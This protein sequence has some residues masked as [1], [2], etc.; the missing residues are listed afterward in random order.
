MLSKPNQKLLILS[1]DNSEIAYA[2]IYN[3]QTDRIA[4]YFSTDDNEYGW[5]LLIGPEEAIR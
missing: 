4:N 1:I 3:T 2:E 5:H